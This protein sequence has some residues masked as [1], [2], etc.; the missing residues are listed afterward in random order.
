M[1]CGKANNDSSITCTL[2]R[3]TAVSAVHEKHPQLKT[4]LAD[5]MCHHVETAARSYRLLQREVTAADSSA[6]LS[7]VLL[8]T[9]HQCL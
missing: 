8:S 6:Q 3:K 9:R 5:L 4:G 7:A 2:V 1:Q